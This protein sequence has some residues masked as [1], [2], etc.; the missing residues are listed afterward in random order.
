MLQDQPPA[1]GTPPLLV[2]QLGLVKM[3]SMSVM[4]M[5]ILQIQDYHR[6]MGLWLHV[7][8]QPSTTFELEGT[9]VEATAIVPARVQAN[10]V[11]IGVKAK[12]RAHHGH[13]VLFLGS[14][15]TAPHVSVQ[16]I[17][18]PPTHFKMELSLVRGVRP[19]PL[20]EMANLF[21]GFHLTVCPGLVEPATLVPLVNQ[22]KKV[23]PVGDPTQL[24]A[25]VIS[26]VATN[27]GLFE[28]LMQ[29]GYPVKMLKIQY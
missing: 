16:A 17:M 13:M 24:L 19:L 25:T 1:N 14:K 9:A 22:S 29:A 20:I 23:F 18:L 5:I 2:G 11:Q 27:H 8:P 21:N 15:N 6:K 28:R 4:W 7:H 12:C 10:L 3:P 26:Y